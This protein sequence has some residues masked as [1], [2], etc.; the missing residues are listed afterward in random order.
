[1]TKALV[2]RL[3]DPLAALS[4]AFDRHLPVNVG[5]GG[6]RSRVMSI[7]PVLYG[8]PS[9][10]LFEVFIASGIILIAAA[11]MALFIGAGRGGHQ[12]ETVATAGFLMRSRNRTTLTAPTRAGRDP[13][14][15]AF[16]YCYGYLTDCLF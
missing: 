12:L 4:V 14:G 2:N 5:A 6:A 7:S 3:A 9:A 13:S 8:S 11:V 15:V 16:A 10:H 1:L